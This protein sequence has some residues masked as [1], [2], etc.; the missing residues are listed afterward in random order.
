MSEEPE[1][2]RK[3]SLTPAPLP[4]AGEEIAVLQSPALMLPGIRHGF[5]GRRGGV[6]T[7]IYASLNAGAGSRDDPAAIAENRA[8]IAGAMGV[9][10]D[11]LLSLY[12]IHSARALRVDAVWDQRPEADAQV[13]TAPGIALTALAADCAP[14]LFA[15]AEARV[16]GAAHAGWKGALG[17]VLEAAVAEML[18]AGARA[19]RIVAAIGPCIHAA[20]YE[21][22]PEFRDKFTAADA[23]NAPFFAP[24]A[25]DRLHFDLPG[26]CAARLQRLGLAAVEVVPVDTCALAEEFFSNRRA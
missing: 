26:F 15:D 4:Q 16:I 18:R 13:T 5:F 8:R 24:G 17:G 6:S 1:M 2:S 22:G 19:D 10:P 3:A 20:S 7:G 21:V 14:V 12:Q 9:A 23:A 11:Q 25:G